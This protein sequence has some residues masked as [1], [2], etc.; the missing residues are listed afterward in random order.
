MLIWSTTCYDWMCIQIEG[1]TFSRASVIWLAD[2]EPLG[3]SPSIWFLFFQILQVWATSKYK[4]VYNDRK[5]SIIN[6]SSVSWSPAR[7][8]AANCELL[9]GAAKVSGGLDPW[10][11]V[12]VQPAWSRHASPNS[13][14]ALGLSRGYYNCYQLLTYKQQIYNRTLKPKSE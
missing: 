2:V 11:D 8:S 1:A 7:L 12:P 10:R 4:W 13:R 6:G 5:T 9:N 14:R 3:L